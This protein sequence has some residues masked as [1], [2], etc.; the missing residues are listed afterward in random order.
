M[1]A[2]DFLPDHV[3][4]GE[5]DGIVIRKGTVGAF[6]VNAKVW[7]DPTTDPAKRAV[8]ERDIIEAVPA[9]LALGLFDVVAIR[10]TALQHLVETP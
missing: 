5:R 2:K 7:S 10:D 1:R 9:L 8:A 4:E 6:I 3:N